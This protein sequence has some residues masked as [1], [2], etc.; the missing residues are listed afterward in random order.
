[1]RLGASWEDDTM[2]R[3]RTWAGGSQFEYTGSVAAGTDIRFGTD[4]RQ[5]VS[6]AQY[7]GLLRHF[8]GRTV[9][10]G[11]SRDNPPPGSVGQWLQ[12]HVTKMGI[13]SYV[14]PILVREGYA[15]KA[16]RPSEIC[17]M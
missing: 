7:A 1:M 15:Q 8:K 14:G 11:T 16:A 13:A 5:R 4:R 12:E 10:M 6:G 2:V 9:K 17:F 3:L